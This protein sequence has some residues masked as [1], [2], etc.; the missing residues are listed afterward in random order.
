M[1]E[2]KKERQRQTGKGRIEWNE[3]D[4]DDGKG[5]QRWFKRERE[6]EGKNNQRMKNG[7]A[8]C[9]KSGKKMN[10]GKKKNKNET[11]LNLE[12]YLN[13]FLST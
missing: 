8:N 11:D 7:V 3:R 6:R 5:L 13:Y 10:K 1:E 9:R 4:R 12:T 2:W